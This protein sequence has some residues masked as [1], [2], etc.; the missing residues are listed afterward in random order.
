MVK[1][2]YLFD[3]K[4]RPWETQTLRVKVKQKDGTV[5]EKPLVIKSSIHG[6]VVTEKD[7]Q[8]IALR[9]VC[10]DHPGTLE[11]WWDMARSQNL[12]QFQKVLKR[13]QLP[14]FTVMYADREEHIMHLFNGQ[15]PVRYQPCGNRKAEQRW[16]PRASQGDFKYWQSS[17]LSIL[18]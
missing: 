7:G 2:G 4:V 8:P 15:V 9:V 6:P 13:L 1:D 17:S 18:F 10:L 12:T 5:V 14:M 16:L 11:Q 3:G